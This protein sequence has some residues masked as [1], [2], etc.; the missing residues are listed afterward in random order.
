[1]QSTLQSSSSHPKIRSSEYGDNTY[2][3]IESGQTSVISTGLLDAKLGIGGSIRIRKEEYDNI[4]TYLPYYTHFNLEYAGNSIGARYALPRIMVQGYYRSD[5][6]ELPPLLSF[7]DILYGTCVRKKERVQ[8]RDLTATDFAYSMRSIK[9]VDD[10]TRVIISRYKHSMPSLTK[11]EIL[12][13]GVSVTTL[14]LDTRGGKT[15]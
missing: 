10:L 14:R 15:A 8:Y 5:E 6:D 9:T 4:E 3:V 1:M 7:E 12:S 13:L 2:V 11:E